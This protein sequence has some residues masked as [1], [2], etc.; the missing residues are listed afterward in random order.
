[1]V[2]SV[3][4]IANASFIINERLK[5]MSRESGIDEAQVLAFRVNN[6]DETMDPIVQN[7]RDMQLMRDLPRVINVTSTNMFP[8]SG[9]GWST[10]FFDKPDPEAEG[11]RRTPQSAQYMAGPNFINTLGLKVIEGRNF[12]PEEILNDRYST[13]LKVLITKTIADAFWEGESAVGK[14]LYHA[15]EDPIEVIGVVDKLQ[16]AWV[17]SDQLDNSILIN[18]D[19]ASMSQNAMYMVRANV[20]AIPELKQQI[21]E[22]LLAENP[23]TCIS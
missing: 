4:I 11:A 3:A 10:G 1:M 13:S 19:Y 20:E 16:G 18:Q 2:L 22:V 6:F 5:L 9:S 17:H 14:I 7:K 12:Y 23:E 8:L 21:K 15:S